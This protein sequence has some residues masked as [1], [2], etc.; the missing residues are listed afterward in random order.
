MTPHL[1]NYSQI[2]I[3]SNVRRIVVEIE[4]TIDTLSH[5]SVTRYMSSTH[6]RINPILLDR[7]RLKLNMQTKSRTCNL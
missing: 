2:Y 4:C 7:V 3:T 1:S 5:P 6:L